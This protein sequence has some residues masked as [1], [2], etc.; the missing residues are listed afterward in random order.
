M[1]IPG[2]KKVKTFSRWLHARIVGGALILGY[3]RVG[4]GLQDDYEV[5]VTPEHFADQMQVLSKFAQPIPLSKLVECLKE[6]SVPPR[7]VAVTF[8]DGYADNLYQVKPILEKYQVPATVFVCTGYTGK[9]FWWDELDRMVTSSTADFAPLRLEI[10]NHLFLWDRPDQSVEVKLDVRR[11]LRQ[12]LYNFLMR[13]EVNEQAQALQTIRSWSGVSSG[14]VTTRGMTCEELQQLIR[15]GLIQLGAHTR[16]HPVL[17]QLSLER[18][19]E[20]IAASKQ[21]LESWLGVRVDGFAYPNGMATDETK[22]IVRDEG[23]VYACTSLHDVV[24]PASDPHLLT[25][26]WQKD[27]DGDRFVRGLRLWLKG[28]ES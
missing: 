28:G 23:F 3:H 20:E 2:L 22:N 24:R 21:D 13:L 9:E 17:P 10:G 12:A 5:C 18:Q 11:Q 16:H 14:E 25:R 1:R 4:T 6:N 19:R 15:G 7:S 26:F 8:D 27:V